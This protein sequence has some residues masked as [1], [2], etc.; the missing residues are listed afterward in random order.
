MEP[1]QNELINREDA[2]NWLSLAETD[3][4]V[5]VHL[6]RAYHPKPLEIICYHCQQA[7]E[8]AVKA[9]IVLAGSQGGLPKRHDLY[10]LLNQIKNIVPID[11]KFYDY[12]DVCAV[13]CFYSC[14]VTSFFTAR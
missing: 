8:K 14:T 10:L 13:S 4:G 7:A 12:A 6:F 5:A 11:E 1:R 3:Y 9:I 2:I